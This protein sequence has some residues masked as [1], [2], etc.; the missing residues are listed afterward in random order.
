MSHCEKLQN[1]AKN[2]QQ[3]EKYNIDKTR[4]T[5]L[6]FFGEKSLISQEMYK[7]MQLFLMGDIVGTHM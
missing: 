7:N 6:W 1:I 4:R 3:C 2:E 5:V